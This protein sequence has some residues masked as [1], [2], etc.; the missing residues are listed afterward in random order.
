M[1][2]IIA[3]VL[4]CVLKIPTA[5]T[6]ISLPLTLV[7]LCKHRDKVIVLREKFKNPKYNRNH[8]NELLHGSHTHTVHSKL[9]VWVVNEA[10][11][12]ECN[13]N[14]MINQHQ[15]TPAHTHAV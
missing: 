8:H 9:C 5:G 11:F 7:N 3:I 2:S 12:R 4:L 10:N 6:S 1:L 13:K 15:H 14:N